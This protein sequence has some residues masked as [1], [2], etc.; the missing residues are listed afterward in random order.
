VR[1]K[2]HNSV[3]EF[4]ASFSTKEGWEAIGFKFGESAEK[5]AEA[6]VVQSDEKKE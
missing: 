6:P 3:E 4:M 1:E 2:Y 5:S